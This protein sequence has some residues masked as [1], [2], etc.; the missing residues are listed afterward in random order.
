ML[1]HTNRNALPVG[2]MLAVIF[3]GRDIAVKGS[4]KLTFPIYQYQRS[5]LLP[6]D[7]ILHKRL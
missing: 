3:F 2:F 6:A 7:M 4:A 1:M 5:L